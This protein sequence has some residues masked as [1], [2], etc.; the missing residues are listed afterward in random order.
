MRAEGRLDLVRRVQLGLGRLHQRV[1]RSHLRGKEG[2]PD[3]GQLA[4]SLSRPL[5]LSRSASISA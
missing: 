3:L 1:K 2:G 4:L 5:S